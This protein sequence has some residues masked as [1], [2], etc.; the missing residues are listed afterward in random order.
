MILP[1]S[2]MSQFREKKWK[3][4]LWPTVPWPPSTW[5]QTSTG[6][7]SLCPCMLYSCKLPAVIPLRLQLHVSYSTKCGAFQA[8]VHWKVMWEYWSY[9]A[10]RLMGLIQIYS[11]NLS[12][13]KANGNEKLQ[14]YYAVPYVCGHSLEHWRISFHSCWLT[15]CQGKK[16]HWLLRSKVVT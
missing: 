16:C 15:S 6:W 3:H 11:K 5:P 12:V 13:P 14:V 9:L 1:L 2:Q 4:D 7:P 10:I 8:L